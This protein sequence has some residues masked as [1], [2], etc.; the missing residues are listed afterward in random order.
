MDGV[1]QKERMGLGPARSEKALWAL[2]DKAG[3]EWSIAPAPL[4]WELAQGGDVVDRVA[5]QGN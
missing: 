2:L 5:R 4:G 1:T 3:E